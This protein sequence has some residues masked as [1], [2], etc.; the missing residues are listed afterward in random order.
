M[1]ILK[2]YLPATLLLCSHLALGQEKITLDPEVKTGKL[3]NGM[4]YYIKRNTEPSGRV[5]MYLANKVGSILETDN[6]RGLAHFLEHMNFNGTTHFPK[7]ELVNYLQKAGVRFGADL[8]AYTTFDETIFQLPLPSDDT[9]LLAQGLQIM[10]DWAKGALLEETEIDKERGVILEEKRLRKGVD[11]RI[12][13]QT[14]PLIMNHSRYAERMPIGT[15]DVLNHFSYKEIRTFYEDWYRPDL[16]A[17]II[18]GDIDEAKIEKDIKRLFS[19]LKSPAKIRKREQ[20]T[21]PLKGENHFLAITDNEMTSTH[22][23]VLHKFAV[24]QMRTE[25]D[26]RKELIRSFYSRMMSARLADATHVANPAYINAS[27]G[28]EDLYGN[29]EAFAVNITL[30][31][32]EIERG[33][34]AVYTEMEKVKRFGFT[35]AELNRTRESFLKGMEALYLERNKKKSQSYADQYLNY[36]LGKSPA[37]GIEYYHKAAARIIPAIRIEEI[38]NII[39]EYQHDINRDIFVMAPTSQKEQLPS[40]ATVLSWITT[41]QNSE[42]TA[43][44]EDKGNGSLIAQL[45]VPGRI[46]KKTD[47]QQLGTTTLVLSNGVTVIL[48]PTTFK[49]NEIQ[50]Y[51]FSPGGTSL[52]S[53]ADFESASNATALVRSSGLGTY[54]ATQLRNYLS[55]KNVQ[56]APYISERYEGIS[57][58]SGKEDLPQAFELIHAYFTSPRMDPD[59]FTASIAQARTN[60]VNRRS[61][62]AAVFADT[63]NTLLY[64][65]NIRKTTPTLERI[66]NINADRALAIYKERFADASDFVFT[67]VGSF[68]I[69]EIEPLLLK[70]LATLPANGRKETARNLG[71]Y[72]PDKGFSATIRKGKED[73]A[74]VAMAYVGKYTYTQQENLLMDALS[75][76]LHIRLLERLREEE[77]GIYTVNVTPATYKYP[78]NRFSLNI[79]FATSPQQREK[80]IAAVKDELRKIRENGPTKENVE[81]FIAEQQRTM[82]LKLKDNGFWLDRIVY[83]NREQEDI[84]GLLH[85]NDVLKQVTPEKIREVAAKYFNEDNLFIFVLIPED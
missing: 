51:A 15:D 8:N 61:N 49:N 25:D 2:G 12:Q 79:S 22:L 84:T 62:P 66:N 19:D 30:K 78:V 38:N 33:V 41:V 3:A 55:G 18:V 74:T 56:I 65:N 52:Y 57:G 72:P 76:C 75:E 20:Y 46:I 24:Q 70:Y 42:V 9:L 80:L 43:Y 36:F 29:L 81:K 50:M 82:E 45:P 28:F 59:F 26:Y 10:R 7:N 39:K 11:Q 85:Y 67:I 68:T 21:V 1:K 14:L 16:Q 54:N 4:Q 5:V 44:K 64:K 83:E 23:R 31:P 73:K 71:L 69:D 32:G 37:P 58:A 48:K 47:N 6:Q 27:N 77:G 63:V 60:V 34:K 35:D 13:D 53:D 17:L 40:E